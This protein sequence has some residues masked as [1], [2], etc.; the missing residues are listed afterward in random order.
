MTEF[1]TIKTANHKIT[2]LISEYVSSMLLMMEQGH[3]YIPEKS[4][5]HNW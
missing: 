1:I 3:Q 4:C 2:D 5:I